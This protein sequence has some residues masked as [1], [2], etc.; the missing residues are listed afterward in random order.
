MLDYKPARRRPKNKPVRRRSRRDKAPDRVMRPAF[1]RGVTLAPPE[2][3]PP[4]ERLGPAAFALT[5]ARAA[6]I[7][8]AA[9]LVLGLGVE[10]AGLWHSPLRRLEI[11]GNRTLSDEGLIAAAGIE[12]GQPLGGIDPFTVAVRLSA[13]AKVASADVRRVFPGR[14]IVAVK[15]REPA[16]VVHISPGK[17]AIVDKTGLILSL[18]PVEPADTPRG[19]PRIQFNAL[20]ARIGSRLKGRGLTQALKML[21]IGPGFGLVPGE[22]FTIDAN[23]PSTLVLDLPG[24]NR[25]VIFPQT[26]LERALRLY[27][28][29]AA[30]LAELPG[31]LRVIDL[32][33]IEPAHGGRILL[34]R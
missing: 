21:S 33:T 12:A 26:G 3:P 2:K 9:W 22:V 13:L 18:P 28:A 29:L 23:R 6:C 30:S 14:L 4:A 27:P 8:L 15:E 34:R 32:R 5:G 7:I 11:F 17:R 20:Q 24:R 1:V 16:A 19:L 25:R 10:T 31:K